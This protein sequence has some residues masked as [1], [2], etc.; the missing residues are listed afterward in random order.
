MKAGEDYIRNVDLPAIF[1]ISISLIYYM[2]Y[3][4]KVL[5]ILLI[6]Q[7]NI[8]VQ[9]ESSTC[10]YISIEDF[11]DRKNPFFN[12][13]KLDK[14]IL[15]FSYISQTNSL[16]GMIFGQQL[17][18]NVFEHSIHPSVSQSFLPHS[19]NSKNPIIWGESNM[20]LW[21]MSYGFQFRFVNSWIQTLAII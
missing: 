3:L 16:N 20:I 1:Q 9:G 12:F 10:T 8:F 2:E 17:L 19:R 15:I 11:L 18:I 13:W 21:Y 14:K 4:L 5:L 7:L 6:F